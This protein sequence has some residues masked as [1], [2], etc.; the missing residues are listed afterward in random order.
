MGMFDRIWAKCPTCGEQVEFQSKAGRCVLADYAISSVPM[1][2]AEAIDG[3]TE[4]C[5]KCST[6]IKVII[7]KA[8]SKRIAMEV[9][10]SDGSDD[11]EYD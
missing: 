3:D 8:N 9:V 10:I 7:P 2:I 11:K 1:G 6:V 4:C 5:P